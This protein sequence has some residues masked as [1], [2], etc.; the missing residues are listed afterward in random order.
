VKDGVIQIAVVGCGR[1]GPNHI[2]NFNAVSGCRVAVCVDKDAAQLRKMTEMFPQLAGTA[3][4]AAVL[5]DPTIDAVVVATPT[6]TH[7]AVVKAALAAGKHVLCEKPL[8]ERGSQAEELAALAQRKK[9]VLMVGHVFLFNGGLIKI[10]EI[11]GSGELGK[12]RYLSA[13]RTNL[14]PIR[15]DV[16]A[17]YDLAS[18][19]IS[20]FNWL[21]DAEPETVSATGASFL[22]PGIEDVAFISLGYPGGVYANIH[23]SWLNPKKVRQTIIVGSKKMVAWD[24]MELSTP[25]AVYD[26]GAGFDQ[27]YPDYGEFLRISMWEGE[28][29]L[30]KVDLEEPLKA[31]DRA[32][33]DAV[34]TGKLARS[35]GEFSAGVVRTLEAA[36]LSMKRGGRPVAL[37]KRG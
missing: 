34:R 1:W 31:Q 30:P 23:V 25:V 28:V 7:F 37:K 8:C 9:L 24:D 20:A 27:P 3:D 18:H 6:G 16:N 5:K 2:R 14:G 15:R 17:A 36:S 29:R 35:G 10:K 12:I 33:A 32:F 21:L 22:Q 26:K 4:L 11:A 13:V 19:D